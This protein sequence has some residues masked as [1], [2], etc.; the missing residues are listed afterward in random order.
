MSGGGTGFAVG[1]WCLATAEKNV[2]HVEKMG[3]W[4][5]HSCGPGNNYLAF[6]ITP[7]F[8]NVYKGDL[9]LSWHP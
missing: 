2:I 7:S 1:D 3:I 6:D 4:H 9:L 5:Y 8:D